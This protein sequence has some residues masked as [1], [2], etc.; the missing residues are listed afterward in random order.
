MSCNWVSFLGA[1]EQAKRKRKV[2]VKKKIRE[3]RL[4]RPSISSGL[5]MT[6]SGKEEILG[7]VKLTEQSLCHLHFRLVL[8]RKGIF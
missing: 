3:E 4:L 2:K 1:E 5:A 6:D 8:D 7:V